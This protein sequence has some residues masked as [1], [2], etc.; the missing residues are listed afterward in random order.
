MNLYLLRHG[1][2]EDTPPG[3]RDED[4][5]L[6][7]QGREK[8]SEVLHRAAKAGLKPDTI[9]T[10]PY[11]RAMQTAKLASKILDGPDP[12]STDALVPHGTPRSLW[13]EIRASG[14][15]GEVLL[16]GHEPLLSHA[17]S[18]L[19][20]APSLKVDLKKGALVAIEM[21]S[22]RGEPHGTLRWMLIPKL[23]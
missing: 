4:R 7:D 2:A 5:E 13:N 1:I 14:S 3:G 11:K 17:V 6:T 8:L 16:A 19:L 9:L 10:S 15:A 12:V 22:M 23:C 18:Y 20:N 21:S